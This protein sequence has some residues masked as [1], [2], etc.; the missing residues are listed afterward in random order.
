M[1]TVLR[2]SLRGLKR[3]PTELRFLVFY[4]GQVRADCCLFHSKEVLSLVFQQLRQQDAFSD[5]TVSPNQHVY[6]AFE[7]QSLI[8]STRRSVIVVCVCYLITFQNSFSHCLFRFSIQMCVICLSY[9][10]QRLSPLP[11]SQKF[12]WRLTVISALALGRTPQR[13]CSPSCPVGLAER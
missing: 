6:S 5:L 11:C 1:A 4:Q 9:S 2:P 12:R 8:S 13:T 7:G 3:T 10:G